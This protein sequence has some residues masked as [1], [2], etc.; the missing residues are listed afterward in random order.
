MSST[1]ESHQPNS[2]SLWRAATFGALVAAALCL[3]FWATAAA[4]ALPLETPS[5]VRTFTPAAGLA[6][7]AAGLSGVAVLGA[8]LSLLLAAACNFMRSGARLGG[9]D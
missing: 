4:N 6:R 9:A 2:I 8:L 5:F 1:L 7:L 3:L